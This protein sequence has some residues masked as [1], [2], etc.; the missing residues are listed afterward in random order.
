MKIKYLYIIIIMI[1]LVFSIILFYPQN[2]SKENKIIYT[3]NSY[4]ESVKDNNKILIGKEVPKK[5]KQYKTRESA[6]KDF[7]NKLFYLKHKIKNGKVKESYVEFILTIDMTKTNPEM[8]SGIY[9]LKGYKNDYE[10]NK[11][12]LLSSFGESNCEEKNFYMHCKVNG[13][14]ANSFKNGYVEAGTDFWNCYVTDKGASRCD[15]GK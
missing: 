11:E 10:N 7:S 8:T 6:R 2:N 15:F 14:Y 4:D 9:S 3:I 13:L 5:I 12:V 1:L